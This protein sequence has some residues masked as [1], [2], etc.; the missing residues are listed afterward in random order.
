[1][2]LATG[3]KLVS[4]EIVGPSAGGMGE[5]YRALDQRMGRDVAIKS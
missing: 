1:M 3:N 5:I 4:Y 2:H